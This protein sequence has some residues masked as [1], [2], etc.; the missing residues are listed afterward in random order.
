V[1]QKLTRLGIPTL[2]LRG[3]R[4][5]I[6]PQPWVERMRRLLPRG[7]LRVLPGAAHVAN[8]SH[9]AEVGRAVREFLGERPDRRGRGPRRPRFLLDRPA[10]AA[11]Q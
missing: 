9:P 8:Y 7:S 2:I 3:A 4:D 11:P 1:E 6:A 5:P 10:P